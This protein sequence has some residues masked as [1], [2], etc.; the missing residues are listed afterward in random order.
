MQSIRKILA[1]VWEVLFLGAASLFSFD[2]PP[3]PR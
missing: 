3:L 1:G 2:H